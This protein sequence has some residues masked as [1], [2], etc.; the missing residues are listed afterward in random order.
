MH[1]APVRAPVVT[2]SKLMLE[3]ASELVGMEQWMD[4][5][6]RIQ[7][8]P[9][10]PGAWTLCF[11][12][13]DAP[14]AVDSVASGES[15]I[16]IV[17]PGGVLAMALKGAGPFKQ[18][19]PVR[20]IYVLPQFD[21]LGFAVTGQTGLTSLTDIRDRKYP[22]R[23]SLRG[24]R[25]HSVHLLTDL[26]LSEL[27]FSLQDIE[28]W[29]GQI[30]YDEGMPW[31]PTRLGAVERGEIEAVFDEALPGFAPRALELGMRFLGVEEA[32]LQRLEAMGIPRVGITREEFPGLPEDVETINF[33]G[34][35]VFC[36]DSTPDTV[37][38]SYCIALEA[39]KERIPV[40]RGKPLDIAEGVQNPPQAPVTIPFH[41]A[42][43]GYWRERGYLS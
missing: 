41:P 21:Q 11:F 24:Q 42:A 40:D 18:P 34:W 14:G 25:D 16:G 15:D 7:F 12:G 5:Q 20:A 37:V 39:R 9:Q 3:V 26:V 32:A 29:G 4:R 33:S 31:L 2:R 36:L 27:G 30:R 22:L 38:R 6:V 23:V 13:S 1:V 8:R 17:N 19:V 43:E 28:A 10:G 35:P